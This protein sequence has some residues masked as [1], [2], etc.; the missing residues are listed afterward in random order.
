MMKIG[1]TKQEVIHDMENLRKKNETEKQNKMEG[2]S[3]NLEQAKDI[4]SEL[5]DELDTQDL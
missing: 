1:N 2:H 4:I 3:S 5:K